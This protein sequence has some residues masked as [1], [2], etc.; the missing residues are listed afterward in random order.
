MCELRFVKILGVSEEYPSWIILQNLHVDVSLLQIVCGK[1]YEL[2][3][4]PGH[5]KN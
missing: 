4:R 5:V 1:Y 3:T 2:R